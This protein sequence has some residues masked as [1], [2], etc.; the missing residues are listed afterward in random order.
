MSMAHTLVGIYDNYQD[1]QAT[2]NELLNSGFEIDNVRLSPEEESASARKT[3]LRHDAAH[4][5]HGVTGFFLSLFGPDDEQKQPHTDMYSEAVRRGSYLLT[6]HTDNDE[7]A[8]RSSVIMNH[9]HPVDIEERAAVWRGEGWTAYDRN[10]A[11]FTEAEIAKERSR[12]A[13][14]AS[15]QSAAMAGK[16]AVREKT[17]IPVMQEELQVGKRVVQ[18]GGVRVYQRVTESPVQET[19]NL[20]E[21]H[22]SVERHAMNQPATEADLANLKDRSF[23]MR[24]SAEEAVVAKSVRVVE[25]VVLGKEVTE[26]AETIKDTVRRS[27]VEIQRITGGADDSEYRS[28]WKSKYGAGGGRYEDFAPAYEY[29]ARIAA[30]ERYRGHRFSD[31]EPDIERDWGSRNLGHPW[32]KVKDAVRYGWERV[33]G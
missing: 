30:D 5:S 27:D 4:G 11:P 18:R 23:E 16:G 14:T 21:E 33:I 7:Q 3:A 17:S 10:T 13:A 20:R 26:H 25:E 31:M 29:G 6:I 22:V 2:L 19:L 8:D 28:H 32:A 12:F 1:A 9:H 24:E 15:A